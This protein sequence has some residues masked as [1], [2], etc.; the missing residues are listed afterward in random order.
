MTLSLLYRGP[1]SSCNYACSYCP[2]AKRGDDDA[3]LTSDRRALERFVAW[4][5]DWTMDSIA[6]LFTPWGEALVREW[7][8]DAMVRLS[9]TEHVERVAIQTNLSAPLGFLERCD[10]SK[11]ALW[12]TY[13][14]SEVTRARFLSRCAKLAAY[15]VRFSVGIVGF[16]DHLDE[17]EAL[18]REL[19]PD[20]Y[21]WVNAARGTGAPTYTSEDVARLTAV[22]PHFALNLSP[23]PSRGAPCRAGHTVLSVD[24]DGDIRRCHFV[25]SVLGNLYVTGW[26]QRL[27]ARRCPRPDCTCHIGYVHRSDNDL[28][29]LFAGGVLERIPADRSLAAQVSTTGAYASGSSK[30]AIQAA[31]CRHLPIVGGTRSA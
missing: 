9:R 19:P 1:L 25:P 5:Q 3:T 18:R 8:R 4:A 13:H 10:T 31:A 7:Y 29:E 22:D 27:R 6:V 24:G 16:R 20:V 26:E 15:G 2:F 21:L 14:P 30:P 11:I 17:M 12:C 23:A 28:Y